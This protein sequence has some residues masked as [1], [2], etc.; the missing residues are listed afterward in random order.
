MLK[1]LCTIAW[2]NT[3]YVIVYEGTGQIR[4][5]TKE[6]TNS[7]IIVKYSHYFFLSGIFDSENPVDSI[8][9]TP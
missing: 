3:R 4:Q 1:C 8:L 7:E 5:K 6:F 2:S 9:Q